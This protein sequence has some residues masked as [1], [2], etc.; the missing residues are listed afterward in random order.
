MSA[1][2]IPRPHHFREGWGE[3]SAFRHFGPST[4]GGAA[5][6]NNNAVGGVD[7]L[8]AAATAAAAA[9]ARYSCNRRCPAGREQVGRC[10]GPAG[11]R[12]PATT[13]TGDHG[14]DARLRHCHVIAAPGNST[15]QPAR[16]RLMPVSVLEIVHL[17]N[18]L[19]QIMPSL[20]NI[21]FSLGHLDSSKAS[22]V[23]RNFY[24][25]FLPQRLNYKKRQQSKTKQVMKN[26]D[27]YTI[28]ALLTTEPYP[29]FCDTSRT[30]QGAL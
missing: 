15:R 3:C 14:Q 19:P 7:Q 23:F 25:V 5:W 11:R 6:I 1:M 26:E 20:H 22:R 10:G 4:T 13:D 28:R 17:L 2:V 8:S 27:P 30:M 9:A 12:L 24:C 18:F 21:V 16:A 29:Y